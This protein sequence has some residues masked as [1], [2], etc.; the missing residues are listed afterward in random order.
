MKF[1]ENSSFE[2]YVAEFIGTFF[3]VFTIG[4]NALQNTA[5][6]PVSIGL[7]LVAMIS[8]TGK[9]SGAHFN[10]AVTLGVVLCGAKL[11]ATDACMYVL[12]QLSGGLLAGMMYKF[13]LGATFTFQPGQGYGVVDVICVEALFTAILVAVV[14]GVCAAEKDNK[15][16]NQYGGLVIGF[17]VMAAAFAI[18]SISGCSLNPAVVIGVMGSN[19]F[20][21]RSGLDYMGWYLLA[22]IIG[23]VLGAGIFY[24]MRG[25]V[26]KSVVEGDRP[27]LTSQVPGSS[28]GSSDPS[29][30]RA[31]GGS[32]TSLGNERRQGGSPA[33]SRSPHSPR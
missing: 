27:L 22:P 26:L 18:G 4:V 2:A 21:V 28:R 1:V 15:S 13:L 25:N 6:A 29:A 19:W 17:T 14:L 23:A 3:L 12:A 11:K 9:V 8:S 5:L 30:W 16:G 7:I 32:S 33:R 31:E 10:P 20:N 24:A